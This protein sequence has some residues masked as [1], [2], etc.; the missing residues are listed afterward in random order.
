MTSCHVYAFQPNSGPT[1]AKVRAASSKLV[2][3][4]NSMRVNG[5]CAAKPRAVEP[6]RALGLGVGEVDIE[7]AF[8]RGEAR[9]Q[10]RLR[11]RIVLRDQRT[12]MRGAAAVAAEQEAG[13][14]VASLRDQFGRRQAPAQARS[15]A[16][17]S[18]PKTAAS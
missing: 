3:R 14:A 15:S 11:N 6:G 12:D 17:R 10:Q 4:P 7:R 13:D 1:T 2:A 5:R 8:D 9:A 16:P 18:A